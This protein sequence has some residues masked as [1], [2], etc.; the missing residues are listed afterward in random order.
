MPDRRHTA[1]ASELAA[2]TSE[3]EAARDRSVA[4]SSLQPRDGVKCRRRHDVSRATVN[5][6]RRENYRV[7]NREKGEVGRGGRARRSPHSYEPRA[8]VRGAFAA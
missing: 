5:K 8:Y 1:M 6:D 7:E 2:G 3:S 4:E